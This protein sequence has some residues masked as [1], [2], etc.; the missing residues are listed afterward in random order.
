MDMALRTLWAGGTIV[1]SNPAQAAAAI[2]RHG[3]TSIAT[4]PVS[5]RAILDA[6]PPDQTPFPTLRRVEIGGSRLPEAL[7][8]LAAERL[9]PTIISNMGSSEAGG[10]A[11]APARDLTGRPDAV[12]YLWP[13]VEVQAL[14]GGT[15]R[16]LRAGRVSFACAA[17]ASPPA[18]SHATTGSM[19][20]SRTAGSIPAISAR[21]GRTAC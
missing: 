21:S 8:R 2:T 4:S 5:L 14:D 13:G 19:N 17:T 6:L 12:G 16:C 11:S 18:I 10:I 9:C 3:V 7:W 20:A 1:V 15:G